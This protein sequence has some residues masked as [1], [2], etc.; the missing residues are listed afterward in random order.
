MFTAVVAL[1]GTSAGA[2]LA[3]F[4]ASR[5]LA[6]ARWSARAAWL[7]Q[8]AG[9]ARLVAETGHPP[10]YALP[11]AIAFFT[12]IVA[13][14]FLLVEG[15]LGVEA[16]GVFVV[17]LLFL[18]LG[19]AAVIPTDPGL[20]ADWLRGHWLLLH[21]TVAL[22]AYGTFAVAFAA[23]VMYLLQE[24]QLQG[25]VWGLIYRRLPSLEELDRLCY[26]CV[27]AGFPLLTA[28]ILSGAVGARHVWG[29]YW[30][31]HEPKEVWALV[32]WA[33]YGA[34]LAI[35][36]RVG[37]GGRRAAYLAVTGFATTL[38]NFLVVSLFLA[39]SHAFG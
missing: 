16:A 23:G 18:A 6:L 1:Y 19:Y 11:G 10:F 30:N 26:R 12:W 39:R 21:V 35:R 15:F 8:T 4:Y 7:L 13:L 25:K 38:Y 24:R 33:I 28:A 36:S 32:T 5:G 31:W 27:S 14:H 2:Y 34:Y 29:Q 9:L 17:P 37:W 20:H 3:H 22:A